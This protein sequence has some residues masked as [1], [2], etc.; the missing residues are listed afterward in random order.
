MANERV[1]L[2]RK[3]AAFGGLKNESLELILQ[4]SNDRVVVKGEYFF[5]EDDP[6]DSLF[7]LESGSVLVQR[8]WQGDRIELGRLT[9]GD[10]FG[11]MSLIDFQKRSASVIATTECSA[12]EISNRVLRSLHQHDLEQYAIIMMNLGREVSRRL[13]RTD[14][15][16]FQLQQTS[17]HPFQV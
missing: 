17:D 2:L 9:A 4:Q 7:V 13:R 5:H 8:I 1:E 14:D 6:G 15:R 11:E 10:C 3:M 16:L 12:V